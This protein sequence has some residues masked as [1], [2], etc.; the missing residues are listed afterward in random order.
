MLIRPDQL[1][2]QLIA[3]IDAKLELE[4]TRDQRVARKLC[5]QRGVSADVFAIGA[6]Q[7]EGFVRIPVVPQMVEKGMVQARVSGVC[8][9]RGVS[10][11]A[12]EHGCSENQALGFPGLERRLA[13]DAEEVGLASDDAGKVRADFQEPFAKSCLFR[14]GRVQRADQASVVLDVAAPVH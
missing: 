7:L 3:A 13:F 6:V 5:G 4:S 2:Q 1:H 9:E 8:R 10:R 12:P 14:I 11:S